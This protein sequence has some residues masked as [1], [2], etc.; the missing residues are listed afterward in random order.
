MTDP[1]GS[2]SRTYNPLGLPV[3]EVR[4]VNATPFTTGYSY[5]PNTTNLASMTYPSG[6]V[7]T[8]Q[9]DANGEISA[10]LADGQPVVQNISY[11]LGGTFHRRGGGAEGPS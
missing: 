11:L 9:Y 5:G 4:T 8:Y 2:T 6:L 3:Q 1:A 7:L 10:I